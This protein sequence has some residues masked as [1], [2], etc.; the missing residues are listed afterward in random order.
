MFGI[1]VGII[2]VISIPFIIRKIK[3][4]LEWNSWKADVNKMSDN[5]IDSR[6]KINH[7]N[8][9]YDTLMNAYKKET[10]PQK[11]AR[12]RELTL[13]QYRKGEILWAE[14][15][16]NHTANFNAIRDKYINH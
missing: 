7:S 10:D 11:K 12:L 14:H 3:S 9:R 16:I 4:E 15:E 8:E 6:T 5:Y 1:I 13:K 2:L